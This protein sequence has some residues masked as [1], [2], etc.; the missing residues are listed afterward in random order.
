MAAVARRLAVHF[1]L[2]PNDMF[3]CGFLHDLGKLILLTY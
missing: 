1:A 3:T 2:S